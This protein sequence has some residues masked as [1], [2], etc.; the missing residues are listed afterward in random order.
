MSN[1]LSSEMGVGSALSSVEEIPVAL[2]FPS[3]ASVKG[4]FNRLIRSAIKA[5]R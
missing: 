4:V 5:H 1:S 2:E 3:A